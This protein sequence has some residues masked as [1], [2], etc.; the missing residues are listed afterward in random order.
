M[1]EISD[2]KD[3]DSLEA[4]L[5]DQPREVCVWIAARAA[6]RVL[7]VWWQAVLTEEWEY[8]RGV[9]AVLVLRSLLVS[10]VSIFQPTADSI[11]GAAADAAG[12]GGAVAGDDPADPK[13]V[14]AADAAEA[15]AD[16]AGAGSGFGAP[17]FHTARA[18]AAADRAAHG[19]G[20]WIAARTDAEQAGQLLD[21]LP[22]WPEAQNPF[23]K[24]WSDIKAQFAESPDAADW[25]FWL[26]WYDAQL[27]GR[28]LLP[29]PALTWDML[30]Q[31]ALIDAETWD[32][33]PEV[34]NPKI[35][36][37]WEGYKDGSFATGHAADPEPVSDDAKSAMKQRVAVNRD[38]LV[39]ASAGI[40]DELGAYREHVRG[41]NHLAPDLRDE[42]LAFIDEFTGR[43]SSLI[44]G[45]P[46]TGTVVDDDQAGRL[47]LWLR[48]YRG[49]LQHKLAYYGSAENMAE[50]TVPTGII[51]GATG[52]GAMLGMP[53]AGSVV[54]GLIVNQMKPG[55]AARELTKPSGKETD[56][57]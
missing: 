53:V 28:T 26:D 52:I 49:L 33:G 39:V 32:A 15:A 29:D 17:A 55:Q 16:A 44:H 1:V 31:I 23:E 57:P 18:A 9:M 3:R 25:Q 24:D 5:V 14:A 42:V 36:E 10:S 20:A 50:A 56:L 38:A 4:W 40:I 35:R 22:L 12:Y 8:D 7:P 13:A 48:E 19:F 43:L 27:A 54:G 47:V 45:L 11:S 30:E 6:M 51:L 2:I 21:A 41:M 37:I 46:A 34:V